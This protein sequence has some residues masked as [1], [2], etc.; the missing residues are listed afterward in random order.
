MEEF[1]MPPAPSTELTLRDC[2]ADFPDPRREHLRLHSL[3][4]I[5]GLTLCAVIC[6]CDSVVEIHEYGVKKF[7]FLGTFLDL[8]NGVPSHDTIGRVFAMLHPGKFRDCFARC[9]QSLAQSL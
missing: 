4:D 9:T 8:D 3:W 5:I 6:G 7:E 1:P 2:F